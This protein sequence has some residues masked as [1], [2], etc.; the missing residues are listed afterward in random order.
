MQKIRWAGYLLILIFAAALCVAFIWRPAPPQKFH[1]LNSQAVPMAIDGYQGQATP[2]DAITRGAL[3]SAQIAS[4]SYTDSKGNQIQLLLIGGTDRS[5]LH[6]PRSCL[7]GSGGRIDSDHV[8]PLT[9]SATASGAPLPE[10]VSA[11]SCIATY[12]GQAQYGPGYDILYFYV[13]HRKII[14]SATEIRLALLS[15]LIEQNDEPVYFIRILAPYQ[16]G[17]GYA[18]E[19][20]RLRAFA[21]AF[22]ESSSPVF[23]KD[24]S[25]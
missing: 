11:R 13:T 10:A 1:G 12:P 22:W 4:R 2:V 3:A 24:D 16:A 9:L 18:A 20:A 19:H 23:L 21:S 15:S 14:A 17:D 6:D 5:A 8:E 25:Q 7:V